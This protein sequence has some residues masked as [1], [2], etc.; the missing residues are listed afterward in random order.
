VLAGLVLVV[1]QALVGDARTTPAEGTADLAAAGVRDWV[2]ANLD[3]STS[4]FVPAPIADDL[5]RHGHEP[6]RLVGYGG[7]RALSDWRCCPFLI[8]LGRP[9]PTTER[10][11]PPEVQP[12]YR[13]SRLLA[14]F[15][16]RG[17]RAEVR[18]IFADEPKVARAAL[19][20]DQAA[21]L[22]AAQALAV[23][24]RLDLSP[25]ARIA[26]LAGKVDARVLIALVGVAG[27]HAVAVDS[28]P[29][30]PGEASAG[31]PRR[32]AHISGVD[33]RPVDPDDP[34]TGDVLEFLQSQVPPYRPD[35]LPIAWEGDARSLTI[36]FRAPSPIGLLAP[37]P[38]S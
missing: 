26:L 32:A 12:A 21:R 3:P 33:G 28:F 24:P 25:H 4:L 5:A 6:D 15:V 22:D 2:L 30:Q 17:R 11:L 16:S 23:N 20:A 8:T 7:D 9:S 1:T 10:T 35:A 14:V 37:V 18:E 36:C 27:R 38:S 29:V 13:R 31:V 19:A 34:V